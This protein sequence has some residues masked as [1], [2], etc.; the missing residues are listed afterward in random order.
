MSNKNVELFS[1]CQKFELLIVKKFFLAI[2]SIL[3]I[4]VAEFYKETE[5]QILIKRINLVNYT[6]FRCN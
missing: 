3:K 6:L 4:K 5:K 1:D 2:F